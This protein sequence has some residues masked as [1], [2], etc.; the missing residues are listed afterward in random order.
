MPVALFCERVQRL[1]GDTERS[2]DALPVLARLLAQHCRK[3][4]A[5][6][7]V[8]QH[9]EGVDLERRPEPHQPPG[10]MTT[11]THPSRVAYKR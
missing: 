11:K 2:E 3:R 10:G 1:H 8:R 7:V 9:I 6:L 5:E 4:L